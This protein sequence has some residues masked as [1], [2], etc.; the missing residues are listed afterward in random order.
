MPGL[1]FVQLIFAIAPR[2]VRMPEALT[3]AAAVPFATSFVFALCVTCSPSIVALAFAARERF[4]PALTEMLPL[5]VI[6]RF[7]ALSMVTPFL[8]IAILFLFESLI[9]RPPVLSFHSME[10][11][12]GVLISTILSLSLKVICSLLRVTITFVLFWSSGGTGG[13]YFFP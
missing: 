3:S 5:A 9:V 1:H 10:C 2:R 13:A 12:P 8:A 11:P 6:V 7:D 4:A